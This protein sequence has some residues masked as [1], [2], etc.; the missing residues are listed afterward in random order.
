MKTNLP[1]VIK[2]IKI[3]E[4]NLDHIH[5]SVWMIESSKYLTIWSNNVEIYKLTMILYNALT[6]ST[7]IKLKKHNYSLIKSPN[8]EGN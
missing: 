8:R 2:N 1:N 7:K 6:L 4:K 3:F 5:N